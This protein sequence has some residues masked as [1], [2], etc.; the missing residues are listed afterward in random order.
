MPK[1]KDEVTLLID[2]SGNIHSL[3]TDRIN[4]RVFGKLKIK[5]A[6]HVEPDK[7]GLWWADMKPMLGPRLGPFKTRTLALRAEV[8]WLEQHIL[9]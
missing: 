4:L 7:R 8:R 3:Y 5:R 1:P 6:S 2:Q 9:K